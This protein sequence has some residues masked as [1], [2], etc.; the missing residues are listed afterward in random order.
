MSRTSRSGAEA[1]SLPGWKSVLAVVA[2][3]D[4]ESFGLGAIL[5]RFVK[6]GATASVLCLTRGEASTLGPLAALR[7]LRAMELHDAAERLGVESTSLLDYADGALSEADPK[8]LAGEVLSA[9][10][11]QPADGILVFDLTGVSG[12]PDHAAASRA[13]LEA[14]D[15]ADLPV[16]A[17]TVPARVAEQLNGEFDAGFAGCDDDDIDLVVPVDREPQRISSLAHASQ[18][19]PTSVLWRRLELTGDHEYLRWLRR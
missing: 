2:H 4:D 11:Q 14:A 8:G 1:V 6:A 12:H 13:A 15:K 18:A 5:D 17:W 10:E 19:V 7:E 3:P 9:L 16:L